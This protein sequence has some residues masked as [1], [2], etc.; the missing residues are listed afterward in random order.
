LPPFLQILTSLRTMLSIPR[1][2]LATKP[3]YNG[4]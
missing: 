1:R 4:S 2:Q 3:S